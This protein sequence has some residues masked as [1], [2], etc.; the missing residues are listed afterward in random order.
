MMGN[1]PNGDIVMAAI[2]QTEEA[3]VIA[4]SFGR[5]TYANRAAERLA[6]SPS[7]RLLGRHFV[8]LLGE[9]DSAAAFE[10]IG[11]RVASGQTWSG[12]HAARR[13]DGSSV[14]LNL[15]VSPVRNEAGA[16]THSVA[17]IRDLTGER[18][19][20]ALLAPGLHQQSTV[21][22]SI[23]RLDPTG[24][25]GAL[26]AN[27]VGALLTL[28]GIDFGRIIAFGPRGRGQII[29]HESRGVGLPA[30]RLIPAARAR[31]LR[32]RS[33]QGAW[34]EAWV[35]RKQYG[36]YGRELDDAGVRAVGYAPLRHAGEP[37]GVMAV[38]TLDPAGVRVIE[39]HLSA[40]SHFGAMASGTLGPALAARQQDTDTRAEI[41]KIIRDSAFA[42][43]FHPIVQLKDGHPVAYEALTR[44]TDG[45]PPDRH[46]ADAEAVGLALELER[47]TLRAALDA[48]VG[49]PPSASLSLNVSPGLVIERKSVAELLSGWP[50]PIV[51]EITDREA[52][53]DYGALR[54]AMAEFGAA[55]RWA[56]GDSGAGYAH[57]RHIIELRPEYV[58]L[59]RDL[60]S[61]LTVDPVRQALVAGILHFAATT[62]LTLIAEGVETEADRLTLSTLGVELGQGYLFGKPGPA[63]HLPEAR[64]PVGPDQPGSS[65]L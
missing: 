39:H 21:G 38:G 18:D 26:A 33:A 64:P 5:I 45:N 40:L 30:R 4:D 19:V 24:P 17:I 2:E 20:A 22:A 25:I 51:L 50:R 3:V 14:E 8:A 53:E 28:D 29:A 11:A 44:F 15:V 31:Y 27:V 36:S 41:E 13:A 49:L 35:P 52:I 23:A 63:P 48:S 59:D 6:S 10:R 55:V 32:Q 37:V 62:G 47:A 7:E 46:F 54:G 43:A 58:K 16:V 42:P 57:L 56:V 60:V 12:P 61:G 65:I 34:V 9:R 1:R